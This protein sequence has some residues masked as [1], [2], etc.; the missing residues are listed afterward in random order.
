MTSGDKKASL[1]TGL[2]FGVAM[3]LMRFYYVMNSGEQLAAKI[4][5]SRR[6]LE[7]ALINEVSPCSLTEN[8]KYKLSALR[9]R[10]EAYQHL[11]PISPY[12]VF[13][14]SNKTFCATLATT[15]TY[16]IVLIKWRD[17]ES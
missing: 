4:K 6:A 2:T 15:I 16:I 12:S 13:S 17:M 11:Y 1:L 7:D 5:Q 9:R 8:D 10:L 14:L 3:Y